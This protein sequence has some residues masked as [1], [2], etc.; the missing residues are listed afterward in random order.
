M[1]IDSL[2]ELQNRLVFSA[3]N[4]I[5]DKWDV[6]VFNV[7][8]E[9]LEGAVSVNCLALYFVRKDNIW[10]RYSFRLPAECHELFEI[11]RDSATGEK[12]SICTLEVT[13]D[14]RYEFKYSYD[15]PPRSNGIRNDDSMLRGYV[16]T[17]M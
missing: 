11:L 8:V 5:D 13:T 12:W 1:D 16:P 17:L 6:A 7:E 10:N 14:G 2:V 15:T 3:V 4:G 9:E